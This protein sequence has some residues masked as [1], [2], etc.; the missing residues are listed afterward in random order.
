M[1]HRE[2]LITPFFSTFS[3]NNYWQSSDNSSCPIEL[4]S[5]DHKSDYSALIEKGSSSN[6]RT[7]EYIQAGTEKSNQKHAVSLKKAA[8]EMK[9]ALQQLGK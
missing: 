3:K 9:G 6:N 4:F 8:K 1:F 5:E 2:V 7:G